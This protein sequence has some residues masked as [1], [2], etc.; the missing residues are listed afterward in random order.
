MKSSAIM[1]QERLIFTFFSFFLEVYKPRVV[2]NCLG[3]TCIEVQHG[4]EYI[5]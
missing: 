2:S 4:H 5:N 3:V 1:L